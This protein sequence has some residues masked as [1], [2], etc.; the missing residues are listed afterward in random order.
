M[1]CLS[2]I[3]TDKNSLH[4]I[5]SI[6]LSLAR[7][8]LLTSRAFERVARSASP[9]TPEQKTKRTTLRKSIARHAPAVQVSRCN[10]GN[11]CLSYDSA[12]CV[13]D[14]ADTLL[15]GYHAT[16]PSRTYVTSQKDRRKDEF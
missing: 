10:L 13:A 4:E 3:N 5:W 1:K 2:V 6:Y 7:L 15:Q 16:L 8:D 11:S 14:F 9:T 12:S